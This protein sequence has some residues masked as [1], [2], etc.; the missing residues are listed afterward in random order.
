LAAHCAHAQQERPLYEGEI[1]GAIVAPDE[2]ATRDPKE[3]YP[4]RLNV[5]RPTLTVY[6]PQRRDA[7]RAAV[8]ICPGGSYRGVS[9]AKEGHDVARAFNDMGVAA[10]V[11][12][13]RTPSDRHMRDRT[14]G[15]LQD[16]QQA[17]KVV[18]QRAS[19]WQIDATHIGL[20]GFSAGGHLAATAATHTAAVLDENRSTNLR[21][22]FLVLIYPVISFE[23]AI[24][25]KTSREMLLGAIPDANAIAL[26]SNERQVSAT[27]PPAFIAHAADDASV[28]VDNSI[29]FFQALQARGIAAELIVYPRGGH[30][31]GLNN[32]TTAD[33]WLDRCRQWLTS[34]GLLE[35]GL[36]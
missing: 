22:D 36:E 24:A 25:H 9:I 28:P 32:A 20:V 16:V 8:I 13:Y 21:P 15:P 19:E 5:S 31:F 17:L 11:L 35:A 2:E 6:L 1:P 7:R 23:D 4:F 34:Q 29:R 27:T 3:A 33:R 26:Y 12:K 30:G 14:R 10:F 18:R